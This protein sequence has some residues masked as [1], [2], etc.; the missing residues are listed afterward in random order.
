MTR[1]FHFRATTM[2]RIAAVFTILSITVVMAQSAPVA[3]QQPSEPGATPSTTTSTTAVTPLAS[4]RSTAAAEDA[5]IAGARLLDRNDFTAAET[6]FAKAAKLN[7]ANHEYAVAT[8]LAHE[9]RVTDLVQQAGKARILGQNAKAESLLVEARALDPQ[10]NIVTQHADPG[11]LPTAFSPQIEPWLKEGPAIAGPVTLLPD[12]KPQSFHVNSDP[13][14][15]VRRVITS[16][17]IRPVFDQP[18]QGPRIRF[19][20][21]DATY[22]QAVSILFSMAHLFAVPLDAK[23]VIIAK[24]TSENRQRLERLLEETVYVPGMTTEQMTELGNIVRNVFDVKQVAVQ[25]SANTLVI[26]APE[27]TLTPVNLTLADLIDGTSQVMIDIKLYAVDKTHSRNIGTQLPQQI[28]VYSVAGA[29]YNIVQANQ[30]LINAAIA[31]GLLLPTAS[32]IVKALFLIASGAVQSSLLTNTIG[33]FG[34]G[35]T[36][37]GVTINAPPTFN[38]AL[39]SSDSR[40]LDDVQVRVG[41]RQSATF[42]AGTRYPITTSTYSTGPLPTAS[43]LAGVTINGISAASLLSN[44]T[45]VTIPQIQYEDLGLTLKATPTVQKSGEIS[46]HLDLKIEALA[47]S[48]LNNIP[49]LANRQYVSDVTVKDGETALL[50]STL[51]KQESAAVS[52]TPGLGELPGFWVAGATKTVETDSSEL[53]IIITPHVVLRRS[54]VIAGPRI[55]VNLPQQPN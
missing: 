29:A 36:Q 50:V 43:Q 28:G 38:L 47:G 34:G 7:P 33:F 9:H 23:S 48:A 39:N 26:R 44:I 21:E 6:Q 25:N 8:A 42:R 45:S 5:Y 53:V 17:G 12:A 24:D 46:M 4:K 54:S 55:A 2:F 15:V 19:E 27:S 1:T 51:T 49:I 32:N 10:N 31:Q 22:E 35:L 13:Q 14:D 20:L 18:V 37:F 11:A 41:D 40:A 16:Y 3:P 52:G 30:S